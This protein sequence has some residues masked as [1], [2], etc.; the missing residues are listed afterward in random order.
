MRFAI[1][2]ARSRRAPDTAIFEYAD[3]RVATTHFTMEAGKLATMTDAE[4]LAYWNERIE[5]TDEF[6]RTQKP[7]TLTEIPV[8]KP[9]VEYSEQ[10]DQWVPRGHVVRSV[11]VND[12]PTDTQALKV[13][14]RLH[15]SGTRRSKACG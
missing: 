9:Q 12:A 6:I 11:V 10:S 8:G 3:P 2:G 4:L 15:P 1:N 7:F 14:L 13:K 5:A